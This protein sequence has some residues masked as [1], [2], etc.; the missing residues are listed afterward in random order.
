MP[1]PPLFFRSLSALLVLLCSL[2]LE[3][4]ELRFA[5]VKTAEQRVPE[6]FTLEDGSWRKEVV[7][8]HVA[9]IV[10]HPRGTL[11]FDTGLGLQVDRQFE[12][13]VPWWNKPLLAYGP[14]TPARPQLDAAGIRVE[15]ILL[16]HAHWDHASGLVDFPEAQVLAPPAE[17]D[18]TRSASPPTILPGQFA[19]GPHWQ[20]L[21]F[22]AK[23]FMGFSESLDLF[24]D[25]RVVAVPLPGH[26]PG[27][28]GLFITLADGR[29]FLFSG[30]T[31]WQLAGF[32]G[33]RDK[34][35][36]ASRLADYD[37]ARTHAQLEKV[38]ALMQQNPALQVIPAHDE[39][40][41]LPLGYFPQ[42]VEAA[43]D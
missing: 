8:N 41:Q 24:G 42:W 27:S 15:R 9:V 11:L 22:Q 38:H 29:Q 36:L 23:P 14:V 37:R 10:E 4:G 18:F 39:S 3:A 34:F 2:Q 43:S 5:L 30:D 1:R 21:Q 25:G 28:T 7:L 16:S 13:E 12:Q 17:I 32:S 20:P 33:P 6:A 31:S 35:W 40:V 19:H 26:T